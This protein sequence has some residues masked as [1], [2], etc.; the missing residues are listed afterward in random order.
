MGKQIFSLLLCLGLVACAPTPTPTPSKSLIH[1][2]TTPSFESLVTHWVI[3]YMDAQDMVRIDLRIIPL[4]G[5][6]AAAGGGTADV[7]IAGTPPP[8]GW[9][10][11][12]LSLEGVVVIANLS[13]DLRS[14]SQEEL[15]A[16][17]N[18]DIDSWDELGGEE[19]PVQTVI[20]LAGDEIRDY[21]NSQVLKGSGFSP[22]ALLAPSPLAMVT[23]VAEDKGAIGFMPLS[24]TT[25]EVRIVRVEEVLPQIATV[26]D[27]QYPLQ[28]E[29]L[30]LAPEQPGGATYEWLAWL[31]ASLSMN[32]P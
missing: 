17:F 29:I 21:F 32:P 27:G 5:A 24:Q 22:D 8:S 14:L 30:A 20:P 4:E 31:Q 26:Q 19:I 3:E 6:L 13:N 2:T 11:T 15:A 25:D 7:I 1:V 9:F 23:I 10:A 18:G 16:L 28:L 12:P